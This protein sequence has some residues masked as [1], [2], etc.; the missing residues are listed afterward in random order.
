MRWRTCSGNLKVSTAV[1]S[2]E[3]HISAVSGVSLVKAAARA[4][5]CRESGLQARLEGYQIM[6][7]KDLL[8]GQQAVIYLALGRFARC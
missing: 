8:F 7:D 6:P 5:L 3:V 1:S 2:G 4:M